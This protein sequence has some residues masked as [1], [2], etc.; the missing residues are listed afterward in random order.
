MVRSE[1]DWHVLLLVPVRGVSRMPF[2]S[3]E[4]AMSLRENLNQ[5]PVMVIALVAVIIIACGWMVYTCW[6]MGAPMPPSGSSFYTI[7]D[8]RTYFSDS[9]TMYPPFQKD[10]KDAVRAMVFSCDS[11][12]TP[13]VAYLMKVEEPKT[14]SSDRLSVFVKRMGDAKWVSD[15]SGEG[16]KIMRGVKCPAGSPGKPEALMP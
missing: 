14:K 7:D 3:W 6:G 13:F 16:V 8:G 10:G 1:A 11:G 4:Y 9:R 2:P 15:D 5:A 12:K